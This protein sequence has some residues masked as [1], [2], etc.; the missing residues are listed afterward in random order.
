VAGVG[1]HLNTLPYQVFRNCQPGR[2]YLLNNYNAGY[3]INGTVNTAPYTLPQQKTD[4]T[5]I[6]NELSAHHISSGYYGEGYSNGTVDSSYCGVCDPMQ[7]S[8]SIMANPAL[9]T[10]AS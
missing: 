2:Y 6:G 8:A 1:A 3:N 10:S 7:Y 5:T 9:T 4:Y